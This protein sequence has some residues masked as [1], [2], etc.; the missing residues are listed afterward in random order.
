[1]FKIVKKFFK[2][3][4]GVSVEWVVLVII[5]AIMTS[6]FFVKVKSGTNSFSKELGKSFERIVK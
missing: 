1:V 6:V 2:D 3:E 4:S 5:A